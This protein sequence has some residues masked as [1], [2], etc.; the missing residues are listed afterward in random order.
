MKMRENATTTTTTTTMSTSWE[1]LRKEARRCESAIE[2]ELGELARCGTSVRPS[3]V[4]FLI[5]F[6]CFFDG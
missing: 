5:L 6:F 4:R 1:E 3:I 2:R